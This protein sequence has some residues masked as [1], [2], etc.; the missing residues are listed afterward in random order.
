M[1]IVNC[2]HSLRLQGNCYL[3]VSFTIIIITT[4]ST[5]TVIVSTSNAINNITMMLNYTCTEH[6]VLC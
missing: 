3:S 5:V 4:I 2:L 6:N 1:Y